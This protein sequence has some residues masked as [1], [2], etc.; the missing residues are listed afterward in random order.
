MNRRRWRSKR[1]RTQEWNRGGKK[2][3]M[4][5]RNRRRII[6]RMESKAAKKSSRTIM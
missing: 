3:R 4:P 1:W 2:W 5:N 6:T